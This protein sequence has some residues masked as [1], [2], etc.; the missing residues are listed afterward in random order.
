MESK[1][2][3]RSQQP[4]VSQDRRVQTH[5]LL[6]AAHQLYLP[7][8]VAMTVVL[9]VSKQNLDVSLRSTEKEK[10]SMSGCVWRYQ[11]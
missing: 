11:R 10:K 5:K 9:M 3:R 2:K 4:L 6:I 1:G 8:K 7:K